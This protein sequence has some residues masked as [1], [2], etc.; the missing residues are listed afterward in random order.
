MNGYKLFVQRIGLLGI[1]NF[2]VALS[3]I[4][5]IPILTKNFSSS[6]YGIWVQFL[7]TFY[8]I[9]SIAGL[10]LPYTIV[11]FISNEKDTGK[12]QEGFYSMAVFI[13]I[14]SFFISLLMLIFSNFI[15]VNLFNGN[16]NV[17]K[18]ISLAVLISPVN[19]LLINIFVAFGQM[20]R[21]SILMLIQTYFALF[22][23]T[24]LAISGRG[25]LLVIFAFV[26]TQI[27]LLLIMVIIVYNEI[28]FKIPKFNNIREYLNFALPIVPNNLS[29]WI[30]ESSDRYVIGII[31]GT[32]YVAYYAPGY[33]LGMVILLFFTPLSVLLSSVLPKH[34][35]NGEMEEV[36]LFINYSLKY[37][38][39][40]AIPSLF[41]LTFL[42]KPI[43]MILTTSQI[44]LNGFLVTPFVALSSLLFG[45]LGIIMNLIILEKKTKIIGS[46]WTIAALIS[47]LNIILVPIFGIIAAAAVTLLSYSTAFI[48]GTNYCKKFFKAY[49][50][51]TFIIK[52]IIASIVISLILII[53]N[54]KGV[55]SLVILI[56]ISI[57]VYTTLIL[58]MKGINKKEIDF[59]K[60]MIKIS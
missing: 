17:V 49:F 52:S 25:I 10:G 20:K 56:G 3:T 18:V 38:L 29:T 42:S 8:L 31:L 50:D 43:L 39:L 6:D 13:F 4:F 11:R 16:V 57:A 14:F 27:I 36:M 58:A 44:A 45:A 24:Y 28:G 2:L 34:Y 40:I 1:T 9:T 35:E 19:S 55:I 32:T 46:I 21:Y 54:P 23:I 26:L 59:L 7:T 12:I 51:Y 37:F 48:I 5:L 41:I 30:V 33:T 60:S 53:S 47:L 22:L 15:A